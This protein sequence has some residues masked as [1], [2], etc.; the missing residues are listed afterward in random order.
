MREAQQYEKYKA[1][2]S[3][4]QQPPALLRVPSRTEPVD[5]AEYV[6]GTVADVEES[7]RL[8]PNGAAAL[9]RRSQASR[10]NKHAEQSPAILSLLSQLREPK[11][12]ARTE[13]G[14]VLSTMQTALATLPS[15]DQLHDSSVARAMEESLESAANAHHE[16][17]PRS[18]PMAV[19]ARLEHLEQGYQREINPKNGMQSIAKGLQR[20]REKLQLFFAEWDAD[21]NGEITK[22]ELVAVM[23]RLGLQARPEE[24]DGFFAE[25]DPDGSG[26]LDLKEFYGVAYSGTQT[27]RLS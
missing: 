25:F 2:A 16:Y 8:R 26:A 3:G 1:V 14:V 24:I 22:S 10:E 5:D 11:V 18:P 9:W 27:R 6:A 12:E 17:M 7:Q 20:N 4:W 19:R 21:G 13:G 15:W 23:E